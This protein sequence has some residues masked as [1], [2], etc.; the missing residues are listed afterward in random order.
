MAVE[1]CGALSGSEDIPSL[2]SLVGLGLEVSAVAW[3][4]PVGDL[5]VAILV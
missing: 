1:L 4:T 5:V 3:L 2:G